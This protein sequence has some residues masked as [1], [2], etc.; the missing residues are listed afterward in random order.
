MNSRFRRIHITG[1]SGSGTTTLGAAVAE[2]LDVKH[3]DADDFAW[4]ATEP[5][6][7]HRREP[8]ERTAMFMAAIAG[9]E[10]WVLSGS[11]LRWGDELTPLFD[12]VV[13]LHIPQHVRLAR[14][15]AR[16]RA[17]YGAKIDPGGSLYESNQAFMAGARGYE[18]G[19]Y[20]VQNLVNARAWL[21]RLTCPVLEIEGDIPLTRSVAAV[22]AA[23]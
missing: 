7:L 17:R 12:L 20:P 15:M 22:L 5:P 1:A 21:A 14:L 4:V 19:E 11:L 6:F 9:V 10:R 8:P 13:F 18:S 23:R 3:L 2:A 16:E